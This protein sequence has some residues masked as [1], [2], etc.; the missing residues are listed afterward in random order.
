MDYKHD[1]WIGFLAEQIVRQVVS[2]AVLNCQGCQA[3]LKSPLL[4]FCQQQSLLDKM[5]YYFEDV[6]GSMLPCVKEY[7]NQVSDLLPHSNDAEKDAE[8]YYLTGHLWLTIITCE[9][10]YYGRYISDFNDSYIERAFAKVRKAVKMSKNP[11][12]T[13]QDRLTISCQA[14]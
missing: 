8:A 4:H 14:V 9:A 1:C 6:R 7:Y 11:K 10:A 12:G 5:K 2:M 13:L 3:K